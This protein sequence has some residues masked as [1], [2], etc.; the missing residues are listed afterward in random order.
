MVAHK[1]V[2]DEPPV[3]TSTS[4]SWQTSMSSRTASSGIRANDPPENL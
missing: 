4:C 1:Y 2:L 3:E